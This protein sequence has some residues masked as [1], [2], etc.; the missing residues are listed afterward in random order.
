MD[1]PN[2]QSESRVTPAIESKLS[3]AELERQ[4][5][6][7]LHGFEDDFRRKHPGVWWLTLIIPA[8]LLVGA[9]AVC[10]F[11]RGWV[12]TVKL[13]SLATATFFGLGRFVILL[14]Q[15]AAQGNSDSPEVSEA[16]R[17]LTPTELFFMVTYMDVA[18]ALLVA[19]HIGALF[20]L[21]WFG[22]RV[23][24]LVE[25]ARFVLSKF[26]WMQRLAFT[27]MTLFVAFPLA[28]T[29]AIGGSILGTLL[30]L[31]RGAT[32]LATILGC[33]I[34]NGALLLAANQ[35]A[36]YFPNKDH[37]I[38]KFGGVAVILLLIVILELRY[39]KQK[40]QFK[41]EN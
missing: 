13:L 30:G 7:K 36:K 2:L 33:L 28:A 26:P 40:S 1:Q 5:E 11:I 20:R 17:L 14:G 16:L 9:V 18:A 27:G 32:F 25:D 12:F 41:A 29:G 22:Q 10:Y 34:G 39:K 4:V 37:P 3:N 38:V 23:A 35:V 21:P 24:S 8:L 31:K 19:F 6:S 15:E